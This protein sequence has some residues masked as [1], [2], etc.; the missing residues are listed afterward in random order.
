MATY[1]IGDTHFGKA[2][3]AARTGSKSISDH[4]KK[5]ISMWNSVIKDTD[6]VIHVGD[7]TEE[8]YAYDFIRKLKGIKTLVKGN[9][10]R[11][12]K[13]KYRRLG[14]K[15][16]YSTPVE[17][18]DYII[19]HEPVA[20]PIKS[21]KINIH[22]H[23]HGDDVASKNGNVFMNVSMDAIGGKPKKISDGS[24]KLKKSRYRGSKYRP[25]KDR[26]TTKHD[27]EYD[28][29]DTSES[30]GLPSFM[31]QKEIAREMEKESSLNI[32]LNKI[33]H[34]LRNR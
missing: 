31:K 11:L 32:L 18:S 14:F 25:G 17:T 19:S 6:E 13:G 22:G 1:T 29:L 34:T 28:I 9:N 16:V 24:F 3:A 27:V 15:K 10:D 26:Q 7:I 5:V 20:T 12:S 23:T 21:N 33:A 8:E 2:T 30:R 4:D